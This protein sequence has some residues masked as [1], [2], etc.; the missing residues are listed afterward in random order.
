M[1]VLV[2]NNILVHAHLFVDEHLIHVCHFLVKSLQQQHQMVVVLI[3][4]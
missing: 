4:I 3:R 1:S 2:D